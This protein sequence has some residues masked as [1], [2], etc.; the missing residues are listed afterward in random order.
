MVQQ[1]RSAKSKINAYISCNKLKAAYL[2]AVREKLYDEVV[3]RPFWSPIFCR[4]NPACSLYFVFSVS[5]CVHP[6]KCRSILEMLLKLMKSCEI[7]GAG[8]LRIGKRHQ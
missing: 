7:T 8:T 6:Y 4:L 1:M 3:V 5:R 2:V